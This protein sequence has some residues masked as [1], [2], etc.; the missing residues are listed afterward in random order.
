MNFKNIHF[1]GDDINTIIKKFI[2]NIISAHENHYS[3]NV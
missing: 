2:N 3:L 1:I